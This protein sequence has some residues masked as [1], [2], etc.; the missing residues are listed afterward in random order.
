MELVDGKRHR[1]YLPIK[2]SKNKYYST[3]KGRYNSIKELVQS[4]NAQIL[5]KSN[6]DD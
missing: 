6:K 4:E 3:V 2:N 5:K 1:F